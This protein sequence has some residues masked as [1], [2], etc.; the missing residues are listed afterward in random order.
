MREWI[1]E[2][3]TGR[4][5][6]FTKSPMRYRA[7]SRAWGHVVSLPALSGEHCV[8]LVDDRSTGCV[9]GKANCHLIRTPPVVRLGFAD[10]GPLPYRWE[11]PHRHLRGAGGHRTLHPFKVAKHLVAGIAAWV[12]AASD[13]REDGE[14]DDGCDQSKRTPQ[15]AALPAAR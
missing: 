5:L 10:T 7:L 14:A 6:R 1:G 13:P 11:R 9:V 2:S 8:D 15:D 4:S 12:I 3:A